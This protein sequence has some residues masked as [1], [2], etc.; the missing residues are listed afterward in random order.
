M[1]CIHSQFF[2]LNIFVGEV[3]P[4]TDNAHREGS[5]RTNLQVDTHPLRLD[6]KHKA[7]L[8]A[9]CIYYLKMDT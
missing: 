2:L 4:K 9:I 3:C 1:A 5:I 8:L 7:T 6:T